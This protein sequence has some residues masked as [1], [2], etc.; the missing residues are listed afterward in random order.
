MKIGLI[1]IFKSTNYG[2]VLQAYATHKAFSKYGDV[3]MINY[4][5]SFLSDAFKILRFNFSVHGFKMLAHD[6]LRSPFTI[7]LFKKFKAFLNTYLPATQSYTKEAL[8]KNGAPEFDVLVC[9]SDQIWNP[10]V[11]DKN[12]NFDAI[13]YLSFGN[14]K[15][16]KISFSSSIGHHIYTDLEKQKVKNELQG[17]EK[18]SVREQDGVA[19]IQEILPQRNIKHINDPTLLLSKKEWLSSFQ[20]KEEIPKEP[21]L[22]VYSVP[23]SD[24]MKKAVA[25][26]AKK[27][28]LK[29]YTIDKMLL[30]FT[31]TDNHIRNA[32]PKDYLKL[33][34]EAKFVITDSFHGT[35]FSVNFGK[36]FVTIA[37]G[38]KSNRISSLLSLLNLE[39]RML[40]QESKFESVTKTLDFEY[41]SNTLQELRED[42]HLFIKE[43][44]K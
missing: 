36:P 23:H 22:L 43:A 8:Q 7:T 28:N 38:K 24:L 39:H 40:S 34:A 9:G 32:G 15:Q 31:K 20:I 17:F 44:L 6:I 14:D 16:R 1:T 37:P 29:I 30:P 33:F 35:C 21:Y 25:Y 4:N 3:K 12:G 41:A 2:A 27:F 26:F 18:I 5:P 13:Y 10:D 42:A 11:T 19:K